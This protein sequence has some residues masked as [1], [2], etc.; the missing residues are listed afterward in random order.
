[1][2]KD[3]FVEQFS[4]LQKEWPRSYG[5]S[6][7]EMFA[8]EFGGHEYPFFKAVID[9]LLRKFRYAPQ[10]TDVWSVISEVRSEMFREDRKNR[11]VEPKFNKEYTSDLSKEENR[12]R[13]KLLHTFMGD[14]N[15]QKNDPDW[16]RRNIWPNETKEETERKYARILLEEAAWRKKARL[17][18]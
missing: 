10:V 13:F 18:R 16:L 2:T 9:S 7:Q 11:T 14:R 1:M 15:L 6:K 8:R 4:R 5:P 17:P 3:Q 12:R